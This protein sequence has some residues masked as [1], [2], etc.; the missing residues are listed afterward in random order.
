MKLQPAKAN[1]EII[2]LEKELEI[3]VQMGAQLLPYMLPEDAHRV[4]SN[5]ISLLK[6]TYQNNGRKERKVEA[7]N[8]HFSGLNQ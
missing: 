2:S 8:K 6:R 7:Q 3:H 4:V 1:G 5:Y